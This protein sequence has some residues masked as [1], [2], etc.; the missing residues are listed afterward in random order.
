MVETLINGVRGAGAHQI[1]FDGS[2]L[3]SGTYVYRLSIGDEVLTKTMHQ[4][5]AVLVLLTVTLVSGT[6]PSVVPG[7]IVNFMNTV[8][9]LT[10]PQSSDM[11]QLVSGQ[12]CSRNQQNNENWSHVYQLS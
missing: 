1:Q 10:D 9:R 8:R 7:V 3:A 12:V 11:H 4:L 2:N 6:V 5:R